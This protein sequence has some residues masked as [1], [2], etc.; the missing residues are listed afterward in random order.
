MSI[1]VIA[2]ILGG[3]LIGAAV[4]GGGLEI[5]ELKLPQVVGAARFVC[6]GAGLCFIALAVWLQFRSNASGTDATQSA[7]VT[8]SDPF[9]APQQAGER[10]DYCLSDTTTCGEVPASRFC[11]ERGYTSAT[12]F[13][14]EKI[15]G[16]K[17]RYIG[18]SSEGCEDETCVAFIQITCAK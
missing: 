2:F 7:P 8:L 1:E 6:A 18:S 3:L 5:K 16:I 12:Q 13:P 11:E 4:F 14:N 15:A 10:L 9:V 17:T